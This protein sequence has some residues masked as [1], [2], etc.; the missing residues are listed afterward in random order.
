[1]GSERVASNYPGK[2][3]RAPVVMQGQTKGV[4]GATT[5]IKRREPSPPVDEK[6]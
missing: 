5:T 1:M 4:Y 2:G 3:G 6:P